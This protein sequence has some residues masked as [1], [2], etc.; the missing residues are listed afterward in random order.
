MLFW[1]H[2]GVSCDGI[3]ALF[4]GGLNI[5]QFYQDFQNLLSSAEQRGQVWF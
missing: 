5:L 3:I 1:Y 2:G 4:W